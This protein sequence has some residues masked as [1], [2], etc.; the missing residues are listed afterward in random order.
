MSPHDDLHELYLDH[1][2]ACERLAAAE[3]ET[4]VRAS[5]TAFLT[6]MPPQLLSG[7]IAPCLAT[8]AHQVPAGPQWQCHRRVIMG[9]MAKG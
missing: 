8:R 3:E 6:T 1:A 9:R 7:F 4:Q 2:D 5:A